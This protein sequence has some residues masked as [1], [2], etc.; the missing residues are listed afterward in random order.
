VK[1]N[2]IQI[3]VLLSLARAGHSLNYWES[4]AE[5]SGTSKQTGDFTHD[6]LGFYQ[7][8]ETYAGFFLQ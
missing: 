4:S 1:L 6:E 2:I 8:G 3:G 7:H 5:D